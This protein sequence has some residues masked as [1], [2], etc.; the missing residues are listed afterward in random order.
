MPRRGRLWVI[1]VLA[2]G[3]FG[4]GYLIVTVST[5]RRAKR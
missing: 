2:L 4:L 3:L 5:K 1:L